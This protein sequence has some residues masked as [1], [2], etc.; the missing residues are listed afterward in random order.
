M[1][2]L[3][4][5]KLPYSKIGEENCGKETY[6]KGAFIYIIRTFGWFSHI[7]LS[8]SYLGIMAIA[9]SADTTDDFNKYLFQTN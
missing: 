1:K 5:Q 7:A 6:K 8:S 3:E 2:T 9:D 4:A